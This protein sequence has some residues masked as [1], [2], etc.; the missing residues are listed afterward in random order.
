MNS[1]LVLCT[2]FYQL[3][4]TCE[5]ISFYRAYS[6]SAVSGLFYMPDIV[7]ICCI[8]CILLSPLWENLRSKFLYSD[9]VWFA[10]IEFCNNSFCY[11]ET[12]S[13]YRATHNLLIFLSKFAYE[14]IVLLFLAFL[15]LQKILFLKIKSCVSSAFCNINRKSG[16]LAEEPLKW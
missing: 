1:T 14:K 3:E 10:V 5:K 11:K 13:E 15:S 9:L 8:L 6:C 12:R 2:Q 7:Q 16:Q 4:F